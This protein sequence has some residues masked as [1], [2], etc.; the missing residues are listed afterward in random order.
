MNTY[1]LCLLIAACAVASAQAQVASQSGVYDVPTR[2]MH[3]ASSSTG[4]L[5]KKELR[6]R[7]KIPLDKTWEQLT[8]EQQA[9]FRSLYESMPEYD[10]P[11][12]PAEG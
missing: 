2:K 10:E 5:I 3:E 12:F 11:P 1:K 4:T 7:S 8:P 9:E 6:W